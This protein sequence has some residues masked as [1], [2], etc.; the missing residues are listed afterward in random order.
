MALLADPEGRVAD[1]D[2]CQGMIHDTAALLVSQAA[3][4]GA[5]R[6]DVSP[7]ELI[8]LTNAISVA[9][10]GEPDDAARLLTLALGGILREVPIGTS[11]VG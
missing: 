7:R 1:E 11:G 10:E 9:S 3:E 5:L 8:M 4:V 2:T 6:Q